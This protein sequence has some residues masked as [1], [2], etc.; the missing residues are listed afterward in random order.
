[1]N[2]TPSRFNLLTKVP[3]L[4]QEQQDKILKEFDDSILSAGESK[5]KD[6]DSGEFTLHSIWRTLSE[7]NDIII[8]ID[9]ADEL[10]V[11]KQLSALKAKDNQKLKS[12][13]LPTDNSML[14]FIKHED[15]HLEAEK[16]L[17]L[18][19]ILKAKPT[20]QLHAFILPKE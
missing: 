18:Q 5:P 4:T 20:V 10:R 19:I 8:V 12:A 7:R 15:K 6:G 1:M 16:K 11:R 9:A 17:K 13:N 2:E 3:Q 14:E